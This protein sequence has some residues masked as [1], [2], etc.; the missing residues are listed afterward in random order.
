ME[1]GDTLGFPC[2][3]L[4]TNAEVFPR[5]KDTSDSVLKEA[6]IAKYKKLLTP[7]FVAKA[8]AS[9]GREVYNRTCLSCHIMFGEGGKVGPDLTGSNRGDLDYLLLNILDP[10][11]DIPDA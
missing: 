10:S 8:D 3:H 9:R 7:G 4:Y 1:H 11:G 6:Q 2:V 5:K